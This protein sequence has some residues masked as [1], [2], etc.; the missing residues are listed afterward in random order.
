MPT[1]PRA[2]FAGNDLGGPAANRLRKGHSGATFYDEDLARQLVYDVRA[3]GLF[4]VDGALVNDSRAGKI[5]VADHFK[6]A[7]INAA[8]NVNKGSNG[9]AANF[10]ADSTVISGGVKGTTGAAGT[11][12]AADGIAISINNPIQVSTSKATEFSLSFLVDNVT[13]AQFFIGFTDT[14]PATTLEEPFSLATTVYTS[15]ATD[16]AGILFDTAATTKTL[17]L[18]S[19]ANDVDGTTL[20]DTGKILT[21]STWYDIHIRINPDGSVNFLVNLT[22]ATRFDLGTSYKLPAGALRTGVNLYPIVQV[23]A[24][25][26]TSVNASLDF[27][28]MHQYAAAA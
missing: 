9:S 16:A 21:I 19:V 11:G 23:N 6:A 17:R 4:G 3:R 12:V 13:N 10:A 14:L 28:R 20:I 18:V 1:V 27:L 7:A 15:T 26:T 8:W 24:R 5:Y 22:D 25:T 2:T